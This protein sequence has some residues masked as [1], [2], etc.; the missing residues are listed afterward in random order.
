MS[1]LLSSENVIRALFGLGGGLGGFALKVAEG[2]WNRRDRFFVSVSRVTW[3]GPY[4]DRAYP[5]VAIHSTHDRPISVSAIRI[6]DGYLRR[7]DK[8]P[9]D[10]EDPEYAPELPKRVEPS[11]EL[12]FALDDDTLEEVAERS[13]FSWFPRVY[14]GV[15]TLVRREVVVAAERGL[16]F[17]KRLKRF[18]F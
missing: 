9:F 13:R 12:K 7:I 1:N 11:G 15:E 4:G 18:R 6:R 16:R 5:I 3:D 2:W 14:V 10:G 8:W 17:D